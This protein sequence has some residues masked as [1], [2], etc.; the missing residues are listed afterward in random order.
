MD[1]IRSVPRSETPDNRLI[2]KT[3]AMK[4]I[5]MGE[6]EGTQAYY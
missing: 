3:G 5:V 2:F 4:R 1:A 6:S